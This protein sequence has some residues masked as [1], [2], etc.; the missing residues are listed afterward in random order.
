[1]A[2]LSSP[3]VEKV[4]GEPGEDSPLDIALPEPGREL[5]AWKDQWE[6][7]TRSLLIAPSGWGKTIVS[8]TTVHRLAQRGLEELKS[9]R[10]CQEVTLPVWLE[11]TDLQS[12]RSLENAVRQ[13]FQ[14]SFAG[15]KEELKKKLENHV[16]ESLSSPTA[17]L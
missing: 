6:K 17:G 15:L 4:D 5:I 3:L 10:K 13:S 16:I 2:C 7:V 1:M 14:Q 12:H 11:W 8:R 9:G